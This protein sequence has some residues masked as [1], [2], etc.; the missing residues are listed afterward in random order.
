MRR[1]IKRSFQIHVFSSFVHLLEEVHDLGVVL[2]LALLCNPLTLP[3]WWELL[4]HYLLN[5]EPSEFLV[6][7]VVLPMFK[8]GCTLLSGCGVSLG[9]VLLLVLVA[10]AALGLGLFVFVS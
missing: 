7:A 5:V 3:D 1:V 6:G 10:L 8:C 2:E 4:L 9:S